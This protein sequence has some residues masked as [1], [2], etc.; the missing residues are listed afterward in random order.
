V[1]SV[2][3]TVRQGVTEIDG[4][5]IL[6]DPL[7]T[8]LSVAAAD[9]FDVF[10]VADEMTERGWYLQPQFGFESSPPNLHLTVAAANHGSE[11]V[12]LTDLAAAVASARHVGP[13]TV[14]AEVS[15]A[16]AGLAPAD[17]TPER[18]AELL[19]TA[20]MTEVAAPKRMAGINAMLAAAPPALRE[21]LL[22]E[23]LSA[24]Y[25]PTR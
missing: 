23:F 9:D 4:L 17:L 16:I 13:V 7:S 19:A 12:L 18:F 14:P 25:T 3:R 22:V 5:R 10:T 11:D 8:V 2:V 6:G 15:S 24:L 1:L 20:G 21:R